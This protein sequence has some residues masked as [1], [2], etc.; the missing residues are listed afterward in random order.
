MDCPA[1]LGFLEEDTENESGVYTETDVEEL[2]NEYPLLV[3][4]AR[5]NVAVPVLDAVHVGVADVVELK[6][7]EAPVSL[8]EYVNGDG[9][10]DMADVRET[11]CPTSIAD[12]DA[13]METLGSETTEMVSLED[14]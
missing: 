6:E 12:A 11:V 8:H 3:V 7:P 14:I 2:L 10:P 9:P 5:E 13:E 1:S 4:T